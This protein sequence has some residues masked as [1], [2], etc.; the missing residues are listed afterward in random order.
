MGIW[1]ERQ[2]CAPAGMASRWRGK[3]EGRLRLLGGGAAAPLRRA[4]AQA[5][6]VLQV[7]THDGRPAPAKE[8]AIML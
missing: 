4:A 6:E 2:N 8:H 3:R 1:N 7:V 5:Q